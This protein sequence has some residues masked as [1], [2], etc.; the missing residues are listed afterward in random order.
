MLV[1][2]STF[3]YFPWIK[4]YLES[5]KLTNGT[6]E[7]IHLNSRGLKQ[8]QLDELFKIYP[9]LTI[10]NR[11]FNLVKLA[12]K[13][14]LTYEEVK[15]SFKICANDKNDGKGHRL[16]MNLSADDDRM[17]LFNETI[18]IYPNEPYWIQ[19]DVDWFFRGDIS[20]IFEWAITADVGIVDRIR[21]FRLNFKGQNIASPNTKIG[22][23]DSRIT[24]C[25]TSINN[26]EAGKAFV[27]Y[28]CDIINNTPIK[29]R[30]NIKYGQY[31]IYK[32]FYDFITEGK[33]T[34]WREKTN[35]GYVDGNKEK[36]KNSKIWYFKS[37]RKSN[38]LNNALNALEEL[39]RSIPNT[40]AIPTL[41]KG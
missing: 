19:T 3:N 37:K 29:Q 36:H 21:P 1:I 6:N 31:A 32:A 40:K 33:C 25:F 23:F 8:G 17:N 30:D 12:K 10:N 18:K 28:W 26:T 24:I 34:F 16:Y 14:N 13:H 27:Q 41:T 9:Q 2:Y 11:E 38:D 20:K 4:I 39:K 15:H 7:K 5:F 22:K 35:L